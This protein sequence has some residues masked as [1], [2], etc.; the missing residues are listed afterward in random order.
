L[1]GFYAQDPF[2]GEDAPAGP[3][4]NHDKSVRHEWYDP[5]G[6]AGLDKVPTQAEALS[7]VLEQRSEVV[8]RCAKLQT[9]IEQKSH[10]LKRLGVEAAA[11]RGRAHLA[12]PYRAKKMQLDELS[13][14]L[15]RLR[16]QVVA[17]RIVS[18]SLEDYAARL[19]AGEREPARAHI[20][21]ALR[22][23]SENEGRTGRVAEVWGAVSVGLMLMALVW[24]VM[25][26]RQ[27]IDSALIASIAL[28]AFLEASFRGRLANLVSSVNVGLGI[29]AA[30]IIVYEF[31]W[32]IVALA[33]LVVGLYVLWDN[34]REL[35]R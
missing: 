6:W 22:P 15:D 17:D 34:L 5:V 32:Q 29:V 33:V 14:E 11:M 26:K 12:S 23:V 21:R 20:S 25:F 9:E 10:Q 27:A 8:T 24:I 28:F 2:E 3:M 31:F 16:A 1:W 19:R 4:Y 13:E 30:L 7:A 18:E 35:R